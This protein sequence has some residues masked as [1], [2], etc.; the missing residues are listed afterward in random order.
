MLP[1]DFA[2]TLP[3]CLLQQC[4][5]LHQ[6]LLH[7]CFPK[8]PNTGQLNVKHLHPLLIIFFELLHERLQGN[9]RSYWTWLFIDICHPHV[10]LFK[11]LRHLVVVQLLLLRSL[12][13][14]HVTL[15]S[16]LLVDILLLELLHLLIEVVFLDNVD[17][18]QLLLL[19]FEL[20]H[21]LSELI[22]HCFLLLLELCFEI[23]ACF[24][25]FGSICLLQWCLFSC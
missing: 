9:L 15:L 7:L 19:V 4:F 17:A 3:M 11:E 14:E 1:I 12:S 8:L 22:V 5:I 24:F 21:R 18:P 16:Q 23:S 6:M 2:A 10:V 25:F 13:V 20:L